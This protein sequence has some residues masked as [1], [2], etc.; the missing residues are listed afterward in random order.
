MSK[1]NIATADSM[2][3]LT[4]LTVSEMNYSL[5]GIKKLDR[6]K[7]NAVISFLSAQIDP[8]LWQN[9]GKGNMLSL[10]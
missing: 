2:E 4:P 5:Y 9:V 3:S 1:S 7:Y 10:Y 6:T 8:S